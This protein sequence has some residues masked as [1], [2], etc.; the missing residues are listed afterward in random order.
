MNVSFFFF[1]LCLKAGAKVSILFYRA[2]ILKINFDFI[3]ATPNPQ[4]FQEL[5][6][7]LYGTAK[8]KLISAQ[9]NI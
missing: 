7:P 6:N 4:S 5:H 3:S 8:L 9:A 2:S 1:R